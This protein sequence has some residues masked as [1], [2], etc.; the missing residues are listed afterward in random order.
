M[1]CP[2]CGKEVTPGKVSA[3]NTTSAPQKKKKSPF[4]SILS[5]VILAIVLMLSLIMSGCSSP[6]DDPDSDLNSGSGNGGSI[7][8]VT[9]PNF[10]LSNGFIV[11]V[12]QKESAPT[13]FIAI[14]TA[15]E[16]NK[17]RQN[18]SANYILMADIDLSGLSWTPI[19]QF[20]G[21]LDGNGYTVSGLNATLINKTKD[22]LIQNLRVQGQITDCSAGIVKQLEYS[23]LYNCS[24]SGSVD[25]NSSS[26]AGLVYNIE[27]STIDS[28]YNTANITVYKGYVA[29]VAAYASGEQFVIQ[30][31]FNQG[32]VRNLGN[33][34][35]LSYNYAAGILARS[36]RCS[37]I[38]RH[39]YN[40]GSI[41]CEDSSNAPI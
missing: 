30:N 1:F 36:V 31:C 4:K 16:F 8:A 38:I 21:T 10:Q 7:T 6:D 39:C 11:P 23:V 35:S 29:G 37:G 27:D 2:S 34:D 25:N 33:S 19:P 17:I 40:A 32:N 18:S 24:F 22:A 5:L 14:S 20:N 3:I 12:Q 28:C 26:A 41:R 9:N 15:A 13:G